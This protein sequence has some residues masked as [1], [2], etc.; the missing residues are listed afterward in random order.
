MKPHNTKFY[1]IYYAQ[2]IIPGVEN[3]ANSAF[4]RYKT[5]VHKFDDSVSNKYMLKGL[6]TDCYI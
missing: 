3:I 1:N 5:Y 4:M 2:Y 6:F